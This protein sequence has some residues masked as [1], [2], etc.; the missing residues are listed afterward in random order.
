MKLKS[1]LAS[2]VL[3]LSLAAIGSAKS[4]DITL[5]SQTKAGSVMLPAGHYSVKLDNNQAL[6]TSEKGQKFT[7]A[8]KVEN[9]GTKKYD[10]TEVKTEKK[11]DTDVI[12]AIE[13]SG[14]T[15]ELEFSE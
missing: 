12:Q 8:V 11:G 1:F 14:T 9:P 15:E 10:Q 6:F 13:L 3:I 4:W 5:D 7:V 2:G